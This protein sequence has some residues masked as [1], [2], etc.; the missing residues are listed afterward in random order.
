METSRLPDMW[1]GTHAC[2]RIAPKKPN[3]LCF[4]MVYWLQTSILDEETPGGI[5]AVF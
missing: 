4:Y 1:S 2:G 5:T 3:I